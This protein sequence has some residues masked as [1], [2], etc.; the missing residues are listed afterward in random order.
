MRETLINYLT[1][2]STETQQIHKFINKHL[3][4]YYNQVHSISF[5]VKEDKR[6]KVEVVLKKESSSL[7]ECDSFGV[8]ERVGKL[9]SLCGYDPSGCCVSVVKIK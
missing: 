3:P 2:T 9:I 6:Y 4:N 7:D 5:V 8:L 1:G